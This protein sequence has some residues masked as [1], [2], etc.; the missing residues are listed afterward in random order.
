MLAVLV[1]LL[2]ILVVYATA[3]R[4]GSRQGCQSKR[5]AERVQ[6]RMQVEGR[7]EAIRPYRAWLARLRH[8]EATGSYRAVSPGG[9]YTGAYQF[10][11]QTWRSVGGAGRAMFAGR[12]EEDYRA[13]Q[14]RK[15]RGTGPWPVCG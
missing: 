1:G 12:L 5:C 11:D 4:A 8:C 6:K 15:R 7:R 3:L 14:L 13:V 10:D 2:L 9:T